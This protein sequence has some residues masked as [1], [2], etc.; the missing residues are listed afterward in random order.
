MIHAILSSYKTIES[1]L[2]ASCLN[3]LCHSS[4]SHTF[5]TCF[6]EKEYNYVRSSQV[7][8][9]SSSLQILQKAH[10]SITNELSKNNSEK[11]LFKKVFSLER[12]YCISTFLFFS[13]SWVNEKNFGRIYLV[14]SLLM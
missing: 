1:F 8:I 3:M 14:L 6:R 5:S 4:Q 2:T 10:P 13:S 11:C 12:T 9:S 7:E